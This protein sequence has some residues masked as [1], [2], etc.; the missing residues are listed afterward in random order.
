MINETRKLSD[1]RK[2]FVLLAGLT[3]LAF[4]IRLY[5]VISAKIITPDGVNYIEAAKLIAS[6]NLR[7]VST[8]SFFNLYPFLIV[9]FHKVFNNWETAGRLVSVFFGSIAI[10]PFFL[11]IKEFMN[12]RIA[13][14]A[15]LFFIISP[16]LIEYSSDVLREPVFWFF[17]IMSLYCAWR[18]IS[19]KKWVF[20]ILA[21]LS[22]ELAA[23]TRF[24]G[25]ALLLI[26]L[27]WIVWYCFDG[28]I[29]FKKMILMVFI[30]IISFPIIAFPFLFALKKNLGKWELGL[31]GEK[32]PGLILMNDADKNLELIP[33]LTNQ[34]SYHFKA[35][36]DMSKRHQY[37]VYFS[38]VIYKFIRSFHVV[39][40]VLLLFGVIKRQYIPYNKGEIPFFIWVFVF[41]LTAYAYTAKT[42]YLSTRHGLL[43]GIPAFMWASIG[44]FELRERAVHLLSKKSKAALTVSKHATGLLLLIIFIIVLPNALASSGGDKIEIKKAG[45]YLKELGYSKAKFIGEQSLCRVA[46][47]ADVEFAAVPAKIDP[48]TFKLFIKKSKANYLMVDEKTVDTYMPGF[49]EI[50]N[51]A[52]LER[53]DL[54]QFGNFKEYS[55]AV[56]KIKSD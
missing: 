44:F 43:I 21:A 29:N 8:F 50:L 49:R 12:N 7:E 51:A 6:G 32:L 22:V 17:S 19:N 36:M 2:L 34:T 33:E 13:I 45:I 3:V 39:F 56:Y 38:E 26:I 46:F 10:I 41:F 37:I 9:A 15:S 52:K 40:F 28:G 18:A 11:L 31:L 23:F 30:F 48:E 47:Y 42:F 5:A 25:V 55:I 35:F 54:P 1:N 20:L 53:I 24:E 14:V 16:R 27:F 4:V